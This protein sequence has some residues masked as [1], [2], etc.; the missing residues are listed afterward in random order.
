MNGEDRAGIP[1]ERLLKRMFLQEGWNCTPAKHQRVSSD[2]AEIIHGEENNLRNPDLF[3][4]GN[5]EAI[6]VEVKQFT[7]PVKTK[8]R[9]QYEHGIRRPKFEDYKKVN[10]DSGIPVWIFIFEP[11]RGK[12]LARHIA[13]LSELD[14]ISPE[15]CKR[16]Y[17]E[18][19]TFFP[20]TDLKKVAIHEPHVPRD[21]PFEVD[22]DVGD[23]LNDVLSGVEIK[24][25]GIQTGIKQW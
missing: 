12:L 4:I 22:H 5:G 13:L 17:G 7:S 24:N 25:T 2:S 14:P 19:M 15:K 6:Y 8:A 11:E 3:A 9:G 20:R 18:Q 21:F 10:R 1:A 23:D 16:Q